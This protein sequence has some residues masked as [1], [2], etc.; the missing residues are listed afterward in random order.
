MTG[1]QPMNRNGFTLMELV[2]VLAIMAILSAIIVP[3]FVTTT[4]K[5]RLQSDIQSARV[6]QNAMDLYNAENAAGLAGDIQKDLAALEDGGYIKDGTVMP[7]TAGAAWIYADKQVKVNIHGCTNAKIHE[8]AAK[9][10]ASDQGWL[11][12][13]AP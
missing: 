1:G 2:I 5:A 7:Q 3:L 11:Y 9:L 8:Q 13:I 6:L 4:D 10:S 12:G